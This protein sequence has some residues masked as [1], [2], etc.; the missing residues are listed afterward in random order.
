M[1]L[2][3][4]PMIAL[5][6]ALCLVSCDPENPDDKGGTGGTGEQKTLSLSEFGKLN[7]SQGGLNSHSEGWDRSVLKMDHSSLV[8]VTNNVQYPYYPRLRTL[9]DG[10][11]IL[12]WQTSKVSDANGKDTHYALSKDLRNWTYMGNLW[13]S[14]DVVTSIGTN[15]VRYFTNANGLVLSSGELLVVAAFR[16]VHAYGKMDAQA[17]Q[18]LIVKK[19]KDGGKTW[20]GEKE[21]YHGPC[22]E[23]HLIEL[24]S[25]E[26]QCFY[27]ESRPW[28]SSS[29]SGTGMVWSKDGGAT[30]EP[31]LG[32]HFRVMRKHWWNFKPSNSAYGGMYCY[33]YQMPV[34]V[35]LNGSKQFAFAMESANQRVTNSSGGTSDQFSIALAFSKEDGVW[36]NLVDDEVLPPEQRIDSLVTRGAAPYLVQFPSGECLLAYGGTDGKQHLMIGGP[37]ARHWGDAFDGLPYKGSWGGLDLTSSHQVIS[38][39]RDSRIS[40]EDACIQI[41][42]F[43]LDHDINASVRT[44]KV[45]ADN[46]D[47]STADDALFVGSKGDARATLRCSADSE[48]L[49]FLVEVMDEKLSRSDFCTVYLCSGEKFGG[50][51][52]RIKVYLD[53]LKGVSNYAGSWREINDSKASV[54]SAYDGN[55]TS[56]DDTDNGYLAEICVPRS[57]GPV[58]DGEVLVNFS[59]FDAAANSEDSVKDTNSP[60]GWLKIKGL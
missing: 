56:L 50:A 8:E 59:I 9:P 3:M 36:V 17:D 39:M 10:S 43:N 55:P 5:L 46:S 33:T 2:R 6:A 28:I 54:K 38:Y 58:T 14:Y 24:P 42:R 26:I 57:E 37:D 49:Y 47:W 27:S 13:K 29:H 44:V 1:M 11:Y 19:S 41:A 7:Q 52:R 48:N 21:I 31:E 32:S 40:S 53:G 22:W 15:D 20:Y 45:D 23:A 34:G 25:G 35:I 60:V 30:W 16:A 4:Y 18:G 12:F 51:S